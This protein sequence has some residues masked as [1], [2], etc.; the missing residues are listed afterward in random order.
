MEWLV[1]R[2]HLI[3]LFVLIA[4]CLSSASPAEEADSTVIYN[5]D[6]I[7]V[8]AAKEQFTAGSFGC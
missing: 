2:L 5:A 4:L 1:M 7:V 8:T 3:F 6:P